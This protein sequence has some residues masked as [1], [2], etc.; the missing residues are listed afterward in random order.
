MFPKKIIYANTDIR[1]SNSFFSKI[2]RTAADNII[3][4]LQKN[5]LEIETSRLK[6]VNFS[7]VHL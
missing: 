3:K 1:S 4:K 7:L 2:L 5:I 6:E